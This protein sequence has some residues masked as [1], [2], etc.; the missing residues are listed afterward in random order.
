[1]MCKRMAMHHSDAEGDSVMKLD[2]SDT[3]AEELH[4]TL[5]EVLGEMSSEIADTDNPI[6]R[7]VLEAR[8]ERL[9]AI[10]SQL[11]NSKAP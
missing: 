8:R 2:L 6:Y 5:G 1:M 11:E 3:L 9:R 4:D 10:R 7:G